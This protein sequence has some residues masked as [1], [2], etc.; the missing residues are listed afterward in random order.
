MDAHEI[1]VERVPRKSIGKY[2]RQI[3]YA[4]RGLGRTIETGDHD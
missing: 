2:A 1:E 3:A 4:V